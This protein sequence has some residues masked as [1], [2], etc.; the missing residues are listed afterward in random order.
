MA[1]TSAGVS[2]PSTVSLSN[3]SGAPGSSKVSSS[4]STPSVA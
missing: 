2:A 4:A 3:T 1:T